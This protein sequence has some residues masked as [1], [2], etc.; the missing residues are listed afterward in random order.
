MTDVYVLP[1]QRS[2]DLVR[3]VG[4]FV[5][6]LASR[7]RAA[8]RAVAARI[9]IRGDL[10]PPT[11]IIDDGDDVIILLDIPGVDAGR[12][13]TVEIG[14]GSLVIAGR[15]R[16]AGSREG[17]TPSGSDLP[18]GAFRR[19]F[20]VPAHVSADAVSW[21]Y[22][23]PCAHGANRRGQHRNTARRRRNTVGR[24][25]R[26]AARTAHAGRCATAV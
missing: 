13:V 22:G 12:D 23:Q 2:S 15:R 1:R 25:P 6:G 19:E 11:E 5:T 8:L 9:G 18:D 20:T 21:S 4:S 14:D 3:R 10:G 17:Q 24:A 16:D 7:V 26:L